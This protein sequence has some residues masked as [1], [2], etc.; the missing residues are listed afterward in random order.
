MQPLVKTCFNSDWLYKRF[1]SFIGQLTPFELPMIS[2]RVKNTVPFAVLLKT[3]S[4][5]AFTE[6]YDKYSA[7]IF[8]IICKMIT[9]TN[10]A[11][12]LLQDV[13]VKVWKN[14]DKYDPSK[15]SLFTWMLQISRN[16]CIDYRRTSQHKMQLNTST[17]MEQHETIASDE[18]PYNTENMELRGLAFKLE[19]KYRQVIDLVYF[20]GYSQEEVSQMLNIPLGTVKT[21]SRRGLQQLRDLYRRHNS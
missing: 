19:H 3:K 21:R 14:I 4:R 1:I 10:I 2:T 16:A 13:F 18:M 7:A 5:E 17:Q 9:N 20:W 6:L 8:S 11:E 15:G 12:E